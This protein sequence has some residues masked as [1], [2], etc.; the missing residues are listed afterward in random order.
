MAIFIIV[1]GL[2]GQR[3]ERLTGS[4]HG[5]GPPK[6][7]GTIPVQETAKSWLREEPTHPTCAFAISQHGGKAAATH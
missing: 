3:K 2:L 7:L 4:A 1:V 6:E 5:Y